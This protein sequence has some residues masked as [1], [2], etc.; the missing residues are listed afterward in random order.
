MLALFAFTPMSKYAIAGRQLMKG[1]I[2][3]AITAMTTKSVSSELIQPSRWR[4]GNFFFGINGAD[5]AFVWGNYN[6]SLIAYQKCPVVSAVINKKAQALVNGKR[7]VMTG[8]GKAAKEATGKQ[9]DALRYLLKRPNPLQTGR[10]FRAQGSIYKQI[11]GYCPILKVVPVGYEDDF[12][13]WRLWNIPP[14]MIQVEDTQE[15]WYLAK[16]SPFKSIRLTYMGS[17]VTVSPNL[18]FFVKENQ[19]STST[20]NAAGYNENASLFLPDSKLYALD[21][22]INNFI[23]SLDSR[24]SLTRNRGPQWLLT[25]DS[26]DSGDSGL[27]PLDP[28]AVDK[29]HTDFLQYGIMHGQRKAI[30]TDAKLRLQ[31]VGFDVAQLKLLEGEIQDAKE[32]CDGL[33]YPPYLLGLVDAKFDNQD[34]AER[35][36]YT[37]SIIPDCDSEDE[38]WDEMLGLTAMGIHL[39]TDFTHL[40]ALQEDDVKRSTARLLLNQALKIEYEASL[41]TKNQWLIKLGEEPMGPEGDVRASDAQNSNVPLASIIGVGGVQSV[42]GVLTASGLSEQGRASTLE[43]LFGITPQDAASMVVNSSSQQTQQQDAGAN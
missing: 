10:E 1:N 25:N 5:K 37:N 32:I 27:F 9:P 4:G 21:K 34:V 42:I 18:I 16:G 41:I 2:G 35:G 19:I 36:L 39:E 20:Y 30:I 6:S 8:E 12:S 43:I 40:P 38:Q 22:N 11:Y 15:P 13:K 17:S 3:N 23:D 31:T 26:G 7:K 14:W 29:L 24:G 28:E 33:N